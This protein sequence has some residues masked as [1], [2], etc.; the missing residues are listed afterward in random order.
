[1]REKIFAQRHILYSGGSLTAYQFRYPINQKKPH[2]ESPEL[3]PAERSTSSTRW[4]RISSPEGKGTELPHVA[5]KNSG[6]VG[7]S[8]ISAPHLGHLRSSC[9]LLSSS[10]KTTRMNVA[11]TNIW[12]TSVILKPGRNLE[13]S[14]SGIPVARS[15]RPNGVM[16]PF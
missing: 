2:C 7:D 9:A 5:H 3:F 4:N 15:R 1:M 10:C 11:T 14:S 12:R 16:T 8:V 13:A 6:R